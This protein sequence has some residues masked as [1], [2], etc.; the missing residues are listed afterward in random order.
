MVNSWLNMI[1]QCSRVAKKA[2]GI[3]ACIRNSV[4]SRS[5]E[6]I[7]SLCLA[8]VRLHLKFYVHLWVP[9]YKKYIEVLEC[10]QRRTRK[11]VRR[12]EHE[13]SERW[14][15]ELGL[16]GL[17]KRRLREALIAPY[18]SLKGGCI[19]VD[20]SLFSQTSDRTRGNGL[21]S[22]QGRFRLNIRKNFFTE[23]VV[24]Y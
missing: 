14:L 18:N 23:G 9:H 19:E 7:V 5:S 10:V 3:L 15:R 1:Q 16:F 24:K 21:N 20:I 13:S 17:E 8:L 2:S 4:A 6:M 12:L 22:C 11:L